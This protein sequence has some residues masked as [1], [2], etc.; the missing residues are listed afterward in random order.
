VEELY[1]FP[2]AR[3]HGAGRAVAGDLLQWCTE[4]RCV[5]V[6]ASALPGS[7][8]VKSFFEGQGFTARLLVMS[9]SLS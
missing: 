8:A 9:R 4:A 3:R 2:E 5:G 1:V 7:R 6:D